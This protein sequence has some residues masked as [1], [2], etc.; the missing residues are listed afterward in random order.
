MPSKYNGIDYV[1]NCI[2]SIRDTGHTDTI[3]VVDSDSAD[4]SYFSKLTAYNVNVHDAHNKHY[5]DGAI[6]Y[7]YNYYPDEEFII[8]IQDS[9]TVHQNLDSFKKSD[10]TS[11]CYFPIQYQGPSGAYAL[12][13]KRETIE[14]CL[15][16]IRGVGC[17]IQ[18]DD[19]YQFYGLFGPVFISHRKVLTALYNLKLNT[20]LPTNKLTAC[21]SERIWGFFLYHIGIDISKNTIM[22]DYI[23]SNRS[24][25]AIRKHFGA[26]Q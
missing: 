3:A 1:V 5:N 8:S 10:F 22:G 13:V 12:D 20:I 9:M 23:N 6:W 15:N 11:F 14:Y 25:G 4:K 2:K 26:R 24:N 7:C 18:E 19:L 17:D 21:A 16:K